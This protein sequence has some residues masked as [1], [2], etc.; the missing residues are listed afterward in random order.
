MENE[1]AYLLT[2][3]GLGDYITMIGAL[4][5]LS[6]YYQHI[7]M[8]C[9]VGSIENMKLFLPNK[10][11][12]YIPIYPTRFSLT[13]NEH[14]LL[15][16]T[17]CIKIINEAPIN[18]DI[19]IC[20]TEQLKGG[21]LK[22]RITNKRLLE[23][24]S[25]DKQYTIRWVH[26]REFYHNIGLDLSIYYEYFDIPS[27]NNPI[28]EDYNIIFAHTKASDREIQIPDVIAKYINDK[29]TI[30]IC[31]N[32]NVYPSDHPKYELAN[33]YIN[34]PIAHYIDIIKQA[35]EIVYPLQQTNR[36]SATKVM[37]YERTQPKTQP[38]T[39]MQMLFA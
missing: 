28:T 17:Q 9:R 22:S 3:N 13:S 38:K 35:T 37:I 32:K 23:Y 6:N 18:N 2:Y 26:I 39:R 16:A 33:Q 8:I 19:L 25:N 11:I 15:E 14:L 10:Q 12:T 27:P 4:N 20:G 36:L 7:Y 34:I 30:I 21:V 29:N 24:K 5:F 31:A 1:T